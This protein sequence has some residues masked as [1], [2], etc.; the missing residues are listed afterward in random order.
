VKKAKN[1]FLPDPDA[2]FNE[3]INPSMVDFHEVLDEGVL[4][5]KTTVVNRAPVMAAWATIVA[6]RL[7]FKRTESL[8]IGKCFLLS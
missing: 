7:G 2:A 4:E 3:I 6:E 8:S 1:E 5:H